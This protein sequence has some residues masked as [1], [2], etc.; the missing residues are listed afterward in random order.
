MSPPSSDRQYAGRSKEQRISQRREQFI[1]AGIQ[2]FGS[3][4]YHGATVRKLCAEAGLTARYFYESFDS[5]EAL[6]LAVFEQCMQRIT[7]HV[8]VA[9]E[10]ATSGESSDHLIDTVLDAFFIEMQ[11][12]R[13]ARLLMLEVLGVSDMVNDKTNQQ[14]NALGDLIINLVSAMHPSWH[15]MEEQRGTL[16]GVAVLGAM[17]QATIHWMVNDYE[18]D[19]AA[20]VQTTSLLVKGLLK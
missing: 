15:Q 11:D 4:G 19:R 9:V 16:L 10:A 7:D 2:V 17:R 3:A 5:T 18:L 13:I 14:L 12:K 1:E 20:V 6:L 8:S